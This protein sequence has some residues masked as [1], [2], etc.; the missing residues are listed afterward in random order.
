MNT[1]KTNGL[2]NKIETISAQTNEMKI[3]KKAI[4]Q[5]KMVNNAVCGEIE[6]LEDLIGKYKSQMDNVENNMAIIMNEMGNMKERMA[7]N[8]NNFGQI[9]KIIKTENMSTK[10]VTNEMIN[11][12]LM[13]LKKREKIW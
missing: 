5:N 12:R 9:V 3:M 7:D 13:D 2:N 11:A 8:E 6:K 4:M 10:K 1:K